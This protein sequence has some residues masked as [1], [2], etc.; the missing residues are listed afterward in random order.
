MRCSPL[1]HGQ[2]SGHSRELTPPEGQGHI[3][4][5]E[6]GT[7]FQFSGCTDYSDGRIISLSSAKISVDGVAASVV[8]TGESI[9]VKYQNTKLNSCFHIE[10]EDIPYSEIISTEMRGLV[11]SK[12]LNVPFAENLYEMHVYTFSRAVRRPSVWLPRRLI[13]S[14]PTEKLIETCNMSIQE[15]LKKFTGRPKRL[16]VMINPY[17]GRRRAASVYEKVVL[18]VFRSAGIVAQSMTT[19]FGGDA[20]EIIGS[21]SRLELQQLDGI[22]AVG[23]DGL[24]HEIVNAILEMR[25]SEEDIDRVARKIRV[26]HI[27]A[28]STDAVACTLNGTRS[29]F[30]AAMHIVLGDAVPLDVLRIDSVEGN[31]EFAISMAS[32]GFMGDLM[33]AS[34]KMRWMGPVRY[35][36]VGA[37]MLAANRAYHAKIEYLP[38]PKVGDA[39]K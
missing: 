16:L 24:F 28:G 8:F 1:S 38:A 25:S 26:G 2:E 35:E 7:S 39:I 29:A 20:K 14:S 9:F 17:G 36:F 11:K 23:G 13:F 4:P 3:S 19:R 30:T 37:R 31:K 34:E 12:W 10:N 6:L 15:K 5:T 27:P 32:Y 21:M 18:P 33:E 22:V